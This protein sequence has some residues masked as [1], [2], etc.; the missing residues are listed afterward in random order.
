MKS[1][2]SLPVTLISTKAITCN[3]G[4]QIN[5]KGEEKTALYIETTPLFAFKVKN[6]LMKWFKKKKKNVYYYFYR[7]D[8]SFIVW[9][10]I[11]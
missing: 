9:P 8:K 10:L 5:K 11:N 4:T 6:E 1:R 2:F 7:R 3:D